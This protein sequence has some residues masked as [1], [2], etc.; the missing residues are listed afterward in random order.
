VSRAE[1]GRR[2]RQRYPHK[3]LAYDAKRRARRK[4]VPCTLTAA[5]VKSLLD[6]GWVCSYCESLVGSF[7]GGAR[8]LSVTLDRLVPELGYIP[9]NVVLACHA[10]NSTKGEH[11]PQ[12]LR[13]WADRIETLLTRQN[14]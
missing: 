5:D 14:P 9:R 12:S 3:A 7:V 4:G 8:P 6:A 10:C 13:A 11:T 2:Y 1:E